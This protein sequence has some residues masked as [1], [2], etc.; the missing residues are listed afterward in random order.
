[1][2]SSLLHLLLKAKVETEMRTKTGV[3]MLDFSPDVLGGCRVCVGG[4]H[5]HREAPECAEGSYLGGLEHKLV[6]PLIFAELCL[7]LQQLCHFLC[8][9][10]MEQGGSWG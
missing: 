1:M 2:L 5:A 4:G 8:N 10:G 7:H 3:A 9:L 6:F